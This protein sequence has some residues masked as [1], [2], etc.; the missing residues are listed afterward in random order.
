MTIIWLREEQKRIHLTSHSALGIFRSFLACT[1]HR[2][3]LKMQCKKC[4]KCTVISYHNCISEHDNYISYISYIAILVGPLAP[5]FF[6][7]S[8]LP[9]LSRVRSERMTLQKP[10]VIDLGCGSGVFA[11]EARGPG[12]SIHLVCVRVLRF[13][14]T[15]HLKPFIK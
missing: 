12:Q 7:P 13:I 4:K 1:L 10:M 6:I 5:P 15:I 9:S 14:L 3:L 11:T 2:I 8:I